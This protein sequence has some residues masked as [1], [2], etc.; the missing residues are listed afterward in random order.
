M[1][2]HAGIEWDITTC[3]QTELEQLTEWIDLYKRLRPLLHSGTVVRADLN[4]ETALLHGVVAADGSHAVFVYV[5]LHSPLAA[6][7]V[8]LRLPGLGPARRYTVVQCPELASTSV[9]V[10]A[11]APL[12]GAALERLGVDIV[13]PRVADVLLIEVT[14]ASD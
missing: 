10:A 1:F 3:D 13:L 12:T 2:G 14:A 5:Q 8:R 6:R 4:D 7:F 9:G 11:P